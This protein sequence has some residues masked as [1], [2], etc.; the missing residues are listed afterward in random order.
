MPHAECAALKPIGQRATWGQGTPSV[1]A[2][3]LILRP[4]GSIRLSEDE[5]AEALTAECHAGTIAEACSQAGLKIAQLHG[6][7][8]R[9]AAWNLP[10]SLQVIYVINVD[11]HGNL[12]TPVPARPAEA[13]GKHLQRSVFSAPADSAYH[14]PPPCCAI[15]Q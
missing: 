15:Y 12:Q 10:H 2:S 8:A 3:L 1:L 4:V 11:R 6:D 9:S 5:A 7:G 13:A 14:K